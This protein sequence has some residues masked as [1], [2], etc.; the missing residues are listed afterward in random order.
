ML[1]VDE[2]AFGQITKRLETVMDYVLY[3]QHNPK[4][5]YTLTDLLAILDPSR[6]AYGAI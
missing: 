4:Q 2:N 5:E 3:G 1:H 6:R